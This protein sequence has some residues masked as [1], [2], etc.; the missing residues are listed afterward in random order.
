MKKH[1]YKNITAWVILCTIILILVNMDM[2]HFEQVIPVRRSFYPDSDTRGNQPVTQRIR[3]SQGSY[4]AVLSGVNEN[5]YNG[6]NLYLNGELVK[7][8]TFDVGTIDD[9][10]PFSIETSA[11]DMQIGVYY[12]Q[13]SGAFRIEHIKI[14]S[15]FVILKENIIRH[16]F[17]SLVLLAFLILLYFRVFATA[18]YRKRMGRFAEPFTEKT[19]LFIFLVSLIVSAPL[20]NSGFPQSTDLIF[21]LMRIEGIKES[22]VSGYLPARIYEYTLNGY[23]YGSGLFY[24]DLFLYFPAILRLLGFHILTAYKIFTFLCNF[25][26]MLSMYLFISRIAKSRFAGLV[27]ASFYSLAVYRLAVIYFRGALGEM[28]V[29][30]FLPLVLW[31]LFDILNNRP[32]HWLV[33]AAGFAGLLLSHLI[34]LAIS[35]VMTM[36][37]LLFYLD[38]IVKDRRIPIAIGKAFI[39]TVLVTAFF[40]GPMSEQ[41]LTNPIK[42]NFLF[43]NQ[44]DQIN[45]SYLLTLR[46]IFSFFTE[47]NNIYQRLYF[48]YPLILIPLIFLFAAKK[49]RQQNNL[50]RFSL[51]L[52]LTGLLFL[53]ASTNRFPWL[54]FAW[55]YN[56]IQFPWRTLMIPVCCF[57]ALGGLIWKTLFSKKHAWVI[58]GTLTVCLIGVI[59]FFSHLMNQ[60]MYHGEDFQLESNRISG[61]EWLPINADSEFIDK[62]GNT[63]LASVSD[64]VTKSFRRK[65]LTFS[66]DFEINSEPADPVLVEIPLLYY[67]GYR[68]RLEQ[69]SNDPS[70]QKVFQGPHGLTSVQ[71]DPDVKSGTLFVWYAKTL[72]QR[73]SEGVSLITLILILLFRRRKID[74]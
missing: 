24:P 12:S 59:P 74:A 31:G 36:F 13:S 44:A 69:N 72:V 25:F 45:S 70:E 27:A 54:H 55:F 6:Y 60:K 43:S 53:A 47:Y 49:I 4:R 38:R 28:Q 35:G 37:I 51:P 57:A 18:Q 19:S 46:E 21:H 42:A 52:F 23:G 9:V 50:F 10:I 68:A 39:V 14:I 7:T 67:T 40:W 26:S 41:I 56:R 1:Q 20:L 66:V 5:K 3:L 17:S 33:F 15:D 8:D 30:I 48:G 22:L 63:V 2:F 64:Y 16:L 73:I 61:A 62:N 32:D 58:L 29:F 11:A 71:I 34:G 65:G